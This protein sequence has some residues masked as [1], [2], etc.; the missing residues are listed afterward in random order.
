MSKEIKVAIIGLDTSHTIEFTKRIQAPD[1]PEEQKVAGM[2]IV[3]CMKFV[4]PFQDEEEI[5]KGQKQMEEWGVKVSSDFNEVV[6]DCD[7]IMIE[8]NDPSLHLEYFKR[9]ANLGKPIFLDKP[10]ADN[11][12]NGKEIYNIIK[13]KNLKVFS[14]SSLRFDSVLIKSC[15]DMP[16]PPMVSSFYGR[17][18]IARAGSSIV[19]YGVH[20]FEMLQKAMGRGAINVFTV[21]DTTGFTCI[22]E[23]PNKRKGL[24]ELIE[25]VRVYGGCLRD[26]EK[27][28]PFI[29]RPAYTDLVK[30]I[31]K[32][33]REGKAPIDIEDTLEVMSLLDSAEISLQSGKKEVVKR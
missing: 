11:F 13:G 19:W 23:Y 27:S 31:E 14:S 1:C 12:K 25:G 33:F 26:K 8:I 5:N 32:F 20:A 4:T 2:K 29:S 28:I 16:S 7:A 9:C 24:V 17:L 10:L 6:L 30:E 15:N 22:I 21:K 3:R 18:G